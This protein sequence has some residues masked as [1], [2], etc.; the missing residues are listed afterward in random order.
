M[1]E[2]GEE[3]AQVSALSFSGTP[4]RWMLAEVMDPDFRASRLG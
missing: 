4:Q 3:A 1:Q 2:Q